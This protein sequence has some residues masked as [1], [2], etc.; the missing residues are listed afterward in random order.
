MLITAEVAN[1]AAKY[2]SKHDAVLAPVIAQHGP[3]TIRPHTDYYRE[4][5][6]SIISQQ[7]SVKAA[8]AIEKRFVDLFGGTYP[9]PEQILQKDVEEFRAAGLSYAKGKYVRDIAQHI[10]DGEL[11]LD[12]FDQLS[13]DEII[14][15]LVAVKGVG[16]WTAHMFLMFCMG[17]SDILPVGDLGIKNGMQ[18][19]YGLQ[20]PPTPEQMQ[21][22][23][24]KNHWHPYESIASWY[25]WASLD[26]KPAV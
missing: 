6:D 4:L 1:E 19:L 10:V 17:R 12:N 23:A 21:R 16:E 24:K 26:N 8:A 11:V 13:N 22:L 15:E 5:V 2:L 14:T 20:K 7:L 18:K 9:T 3:C 25:I